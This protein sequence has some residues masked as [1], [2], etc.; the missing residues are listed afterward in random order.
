MQSLLR[1]IGGRIE[2]EELSGGFL[3]ERKGKVVIKIGGS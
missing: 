2:V 3:K 1:V